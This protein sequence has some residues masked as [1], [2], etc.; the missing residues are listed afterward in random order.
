MKKKQSWTQQTRDHDSP[1][2]VSWA[3]CQA[4]ESR[5]MIHVVRILSLHFHEPQ[6]WFSMLVGILCAKN[7]SPFKKKKKAMH[8]HLWPA[9]LSMCVC[10]YICACMWVYAYICVTK[11]MGK[12][13]KFFISTWS[14]SNIWRSTFTKRLSFF[15]SCSKSPKY[16]TILCLASPFKEL[17]RHEAP[18]KSEFTVYLRRPVTDSN[19]TTSNIWRQV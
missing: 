14:R 3:V 18:Q 13:M 9:C 11:W 17:W 1:A 19:Q 15:S 16:Y 7:T 4:Q 6:A 5:H 2:R 8:L 12:W 10:V